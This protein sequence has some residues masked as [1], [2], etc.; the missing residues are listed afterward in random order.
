MKRIKL[1]ITALSPLAIAGKK[2]GSVSV[3]EDH[4]P[5]SVIR[6]AI[7]SQILQ[8]SGITNQ[9]LATD[10]GDFTTLFL[11]D[12]PAIFQNAYPAVATVVKKSFLIN[13]KNPD[14][15]KYDIISQVVN[16]D[17]MVL[18]ATAVSSKNDSG[19]QPKGNGVFDTLIDRF[20][21]DAYNFP[22]DPSDPKSI[23]DKTDARVEPYSGFYSCKDGK[24]HS[25][26]VSTRFLTRVGINRRRATSEEEILYS[27][28]VL[29]E[30]FVQNPQEKNWH[31][32]IYRSAILVNNEDLAKSLAKFINDNSLIFRLGGAT[33][34]GLGKVKI[35]GE[36]DNSVPDID[37]RIHK[38]NQ[39][40][41]NRWKRWV[42]FGKP[43]NNLI[44]NRSYFTIDLQSDAI[45]TEN[46]RHTTVISEKMLKQF[47][48]IKDDDSL[49]LHT[50]YST[51]NY[52]SGW[53]AAWGLMKDIE[54][55]TTRGAVYL[56]S[57]NKEKAE[58]WTDKLKELEL[59]GVG[60]RTCEGF[61]QVQICNEFHSVFRENAK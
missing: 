52:R 30:S 27:I 37:K 43:D 45:L 15:E 19:F 22:Y 24:Y 57:V 12:E 55:V 31:T 44:E 41:E 16:D 33:S 34:R 2:P 5:G 26:S 48:G 54:L 61:G 3:A 28:E 39:Q 46:W 49:E 56:F 8:V 40:L 58:E 18:P 38:F 59:K 1:K 7:A 42:V 51:Y 53:N 29:N 9:D 11:D 25:H 6:G 13:K 36:L 20:C 47:T 21:A 50:A 14:K 4:I 35:E 10:G 17:V 23:K 60:D 32:V